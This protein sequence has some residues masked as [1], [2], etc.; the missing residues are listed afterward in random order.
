MNL[1]EHYIEEIYDVDTVDIKSGD[2]NNIVISFVQVDMMVECYGRHQ[3]VQT[4]FA[5]MEEWEA[6]KEQGYYMA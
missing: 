3:R 6:V 1:L 5:N 2:S 4:S